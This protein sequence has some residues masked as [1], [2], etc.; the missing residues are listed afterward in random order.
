MGKCFY[1]L[2][3]LD[4]IFTL[5]SALNLGL[6]INVYYAFLISVLVLNVL[7]ILKRSLSLIL[8]RLVSSPLKR[9]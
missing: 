4:Y 5:F 2:L 7:H 9:I 3:I 1:I 8:F 6:L